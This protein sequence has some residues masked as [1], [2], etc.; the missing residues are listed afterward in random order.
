[1]FQVEQ[2]NTLN[3]QLSCGTTAVVALVTGNKLYVANVGDS[4]AL[5]CKT[6]KYGVHKVV[7][8][9][10]DHDLGNEDEI[11]RLFNLGLKFEKGQ[12]ESYINFHINNI[13]KQ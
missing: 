5:L 10:V 1:M 13:N 6:D 7:Q 8:L 4:R 12:C 2:L 11:L 3:N 9:S